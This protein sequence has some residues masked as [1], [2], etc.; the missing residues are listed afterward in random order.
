MKKLICFSLWGSDKK[1]LHG[2]L[3]NAELSNE[4]Y[5]EWTCRYY[6][7]KDNTPKNI[8]DKLESYNN[9]EIV[10]NDELDS[11]SQRILRFAPLCESDVDYFIVRDLD[12]RV[13]KREAAAVDQWIQSGADYHI[14]RDNVE[15]GIV[16]MAGM[17]GS[18]GNLLPDFYQLVEEHGKNMGEAFH[19]EPQ[20][21]QAFLRSYV[22]PTIQSALVHDESTYIGGSPYPVSREEGQ[23]PNFIG[24]SFEDFVYDGIDYE[25]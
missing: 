18:K 4:F 17:W 22:V 12:S 9:C 10:W 15:H 5:P 16:M 7:S 8:C 2:A 21:D 20:V 23:I 25:L 11:Q 1:Y 19:V 3:E 14:M 24:E 6:I 13:G